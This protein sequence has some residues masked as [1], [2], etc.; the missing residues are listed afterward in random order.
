MDLVVSLLIALS[1]ILGL[2]IIGVGLGVYYGTS[3]DTS[4]EVIEV[5]EEKV[6]ELGELVLEQDEVIVASSILFE[7]SFDSTPS[8]VLS[9]SEENLQLSSSNV[10]NTGFDIEC[11]YLVPDNG[12]YKIGLQSGFI[13]P[14]SVLL[15]NNLPSCVYMGSSDSLQFSSATDNGKTWL[16]P[17]QIDTNVNGNNKDMILVDGNPAIVYTMLDGTFRYCR[18]T[19]ALGSAWDTP[20]TIDS[21]GASTGIS[22]SLKIV[23][24]LPSVAYIFADDDSVRYVVGSDST[25]SS[26]ETPTTVSSLQTFIGVEMVIQTNNQPF[27]V[28]AVSS[29][30]YV[31][32]SSDFGASWDVVSLVTSNFGVF[33]SVSVLGSGDISIFYTT[34]FGSPGN[35]EQVTM[36]SSGWGSPEVIITG[37][38]LGDVNSIIH[39]GRAVIFQ[40]I[41]NVPNS[42]FTLNAIWNSDGVWNDLIQINTQDVNLYSGQTGFCF[43]EDIFYAVM[44]MANINLYSCIPIPLQSTISWSAQ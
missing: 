20:V 12:F 22:P 39:N 34:I 33:F 17:V 31:T 7:K 11:E 18:A 40:F 42:N 29:D 32:S 38:N 3:G 13:I 2:G 26:W 6:G 28:A 4:V 5:I 16:D 10:T 44:S 43:S 37:E 24:G 25:G 9:S 23:N 8:I 27:I 1:V 30:I 21:D 41:D 15:S 35:L 19:N 36:G 14:A